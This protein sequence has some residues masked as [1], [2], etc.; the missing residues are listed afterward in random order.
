MRAWEQHCNLPTPGPSIFI[1]EDFAQ[2]KLFVQTVRGEDT[3]N[4]WRFPVG[5]PATIPYPGNYS[6]TLSNRELSHTAPGEDVF[7][8]SGIG[9]D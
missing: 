8:F 3:K 4:E 6:R 5:P 9:F 1:L 7:G 2:L